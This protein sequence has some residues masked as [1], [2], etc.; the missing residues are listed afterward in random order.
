MSDD[1]AVIKSTHILI[2]DSVG[3]EVVVRSGHMAESFTPVVCGM[4]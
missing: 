2:M 1:C 3:L 4:H